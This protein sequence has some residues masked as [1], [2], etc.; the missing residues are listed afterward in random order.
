MKLL[1]TVAAAAAA[2]ALAVVASVDA[3]GAMAAPAV[4]RPHAHSVPRTSRGHAA[5]PVINIVSQNQSGKFVSQV[6]CRGAHVPPPLH[7]RAPGAPL[8]LS[9]TGPSAGVSR[10]LRKPKAY[11][12]VYTC[13][14]VIKQ[15]VVKK[16]FPK[17]TVSTGF[18]GE[19]GHVSRHHPAG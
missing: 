17:V 10:A 2:T 19:A 12:T 15:R 13:T 5:D 4:T 18:G 16:R 7:L 6:S 11:V 9:G 3:S 8:T 1:P 14:I